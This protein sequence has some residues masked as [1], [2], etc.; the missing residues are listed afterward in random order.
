LFDIERNK[1]IDCRVYLEGNRIDDKHFHYDHL[2]D[3]VIGY[4]QMHTIT[5]IC[6]QEY[7]QENFTGLRKKKVMWL[8]KRTFSEEERE[9]GYRF[10]EGMYL[11][12]GAN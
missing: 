8:K 10:T 4:R 9:L 3:D 11:F 5:T 1:W 7:Y 6:D 2:N 12:G